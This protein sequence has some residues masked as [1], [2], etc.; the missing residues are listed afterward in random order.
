MKISLTCDYK[1]CGS[2]EV[3]LK[4][5]ENNRVAQLSRTI[6]PSEAEGEIIGVANS[7]A[8]Q[9]SPSGKPSDTTVREEKK[10]LFF[11]R[12][13]EDVPELEKGA[14]DGLSSNS[15]IR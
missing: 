10:N 3:K 7:A 9:P 2:K 1:K 15:R 13:L 8:G 4:T 5:G 12:E 11:E 14:A 6:P